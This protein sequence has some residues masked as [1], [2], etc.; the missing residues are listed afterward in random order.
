[1]ACFGGF[2]EPYGI[3]RPQKHILN[4]YTPSERECLLYPTLS[5]RLFKYCS[6]IWVF[7]RVYWPRAHR[8]YVSGEMCSSR[9]HS[10]GRR[11][12]AAR[13]RS[14]EGYIRKH[15]F[16]RRPPPEFGTRGGGRPRRP[17]SKRWGWTAPPSACKNKFVRQIREGFARPNL[18]RGGG[19]PRRPPPRF[20]QSLHELPE[21]FHESMLYYPANMGRPAPPRRAAHGARPRRA[22]RP[23]GRHARRELT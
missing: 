22:V 19:R 16:G 23:D 4:Y 3:R 13:P 15:A 17:P 11:S 12:G 2:F 10:R 7:F 20:T 5:N 9:A 8:R 14:W 1:M 6:R 18:V 21:S